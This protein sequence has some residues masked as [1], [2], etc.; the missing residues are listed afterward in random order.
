MASDKS[1]N[2][3]RRRAIGAM[4]T[5]LVAVAATAKIGKAQAAPTAE[6]PNAGKRAVVKNPAVVGDDA[7]V[8]TFHE[9]FT[10]DLSPTEVPGVVEKINYK[11]RAY[12]KTM[13]N[14]RKPAKEDKV[15]AKQVLFSTEREFKR[16]ADQL[17]KKQISA[18]QAR[19]EG[20]AAL[21]RYVQQLNRFQQA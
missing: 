18:A 14:A 16:I 6:K 5:A 15:L 17:A 8:P 9:M 3:G 1:P 21:V 12:M 13:L 19:Q 10:D 20:K 7:A 4:T 2:M 11:T